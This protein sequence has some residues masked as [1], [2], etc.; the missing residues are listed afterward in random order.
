MTKTQSKILSYIKKYGFYYSDFNPIMLKNLYGDDLKDLYTCR[1]E[2]DKFLELLCKFHI[3]TFHRSSDSKKR[4]DT[5]NR[6]RRYRLNRKQD[7]SLTQV[8]IKKDLKA[9]LKNYCIK[10]NI[11]I[12]EYI[13]NLI[14][15]DLNSL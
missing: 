9:K 6:Q 4:N 13:N 2:K 12:Q 5:L 14:S 10:N 11:T 3:L 15:N 1:I 8:Y 7:Y